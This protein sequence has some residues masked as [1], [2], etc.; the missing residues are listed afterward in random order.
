MSKKSFTEGIMAHFEE[1]KSHA[2]DSVFE[3]TLCSAP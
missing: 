1:C 3:L 2:S